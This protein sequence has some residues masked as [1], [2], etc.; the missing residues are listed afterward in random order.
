MRQLEAAGYTVKRLEM[1]WEA[2]IDEVYPH[3]INLLCAEMAEVHAEW[4]ETYRDAYGRSTLK[5]IEH[6]QTIT[7]EQQAEYR[8]KQTQL[9]E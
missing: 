9:R 3:T 5:G 7:P 4:F 8:A 1:P 6:G 2:I